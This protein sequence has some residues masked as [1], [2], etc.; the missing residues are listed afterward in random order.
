[1]GK[2]TV[3]DLPV[4]N[5]SFF[6]VCSG[7]VLLFLVLAIYPN[8]G[9]LTEMDAEIARLNARME[10]QK[11]LIPLVN[12]L[13]RLMNSEKME[14]LDLP[15]KTKI[16][17]G[18]TE[19]VAARIREIAVAA[20][21]QASEIRPDADAATGNPALLAMRVALTGD[22]MKLQAFLSELIAAPYVEAVDDIRLQA[23]GKHEFMLMNVFI[24]MER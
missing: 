5:L 14:N 23:A 19:K 1:M 16:K 13:I 10:D 11:R 7:G 3:A 22:F 17:A 24:A 2:F 18:E 12:K 15:E 21:L 6:L 4:R 20:G 9:A 8:R